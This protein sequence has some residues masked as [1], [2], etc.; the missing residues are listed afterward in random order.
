MPECVEGLSDYIDS[1]FDSK[2]YEDLRTLL[3][4]I[5]IAVV[6]NCSQ[7]RASTYQHYFNHHYTPLKDIELSVIRNVIL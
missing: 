3:R 7:W 6:T 1:K 4:N 2:M 5:W